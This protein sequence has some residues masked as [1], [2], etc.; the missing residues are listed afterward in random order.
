MEERQSRPRPK[1][2]NP[3]IRRAC[4]QPGEPPS[5]PLESLIRNCRLGRGV[6]E[7]SPVDALLSA[8]P[9]SVKWSTLQVCKGRGVRPPAR[10]CPRTLARGAVQTSASPPPCRHH[11]WPVSFWGCYHQI[12]KHAPPSP[13]LQETHRDGDPGGLCG[14]RKG[15]SRLGADSNVWFCFGSFPGIFSREFLY[16]RSISSFQVRL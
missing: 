12:S 6:R 2:R 5:P 8:E 13:S 11:P 10:T 14:P 16:T 7:R 4:P 1:T 15:F 3:N 9:R